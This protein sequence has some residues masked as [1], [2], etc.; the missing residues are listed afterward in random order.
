VSTQ[1]AVLRPSVRA[2]FRTI[3]S[4]WPAAIALLLIAIY[5]AAVA[6]GT[7]VLYPLVIAALLASLALYFR[8]VQI[9]VD[10]DAV[11]K[12][13]I[14]GITRSWPIAEVRGCAFR[15]VQFP[16]IGRP[17]DLIIVYGAGQR[18]LFTIRRAYWDPSAPRQLAVALG[19]PHV[20][21]LFASTSKS[22]VQSEFPGALSFAQRYNW[23]VFGGGTLVA[24][25]VL[26]TLDSTCKNHFT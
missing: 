19:H 24:I 2:Y 6:P 7:V 4:R 22:A 17:V 10:S 18:V 16:G 26:V 9:E 15:S 3:K 14:L 12:R 20:D 23:L 1:P 21:A 8:V 5:D 13:G 25:A 11:R